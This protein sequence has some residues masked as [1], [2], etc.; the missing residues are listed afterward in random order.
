MSLPDHA[1]EVPGRKPRDD[2]ID[3]YGLTH[4]GKV[5]KT[6]NDQFLLGAVH[7]RLE[8]RLTSLSKL[9]RQSL[10]DER[11]AFV[12]M[13]ADGVGG[14]EKGGEASRVAL[15]TVSEYVATSMRAYYSADAREETFAAALQ[16]AAMRC[17]A[18]V[19]EVAKARDD[20]QGMATTLTLW[21]GVW[22][23]IYLLQVG[24]S[25][26]YM[27]HLGRL[28]QVTRDQ[29][30]AEDLVDQGVFTR[31]V[32]DRTRWA[33]VLSSALG[34]QTAAPTVTRIRSEWDA[35]HLLCSDGLTKHVTD[36]RI[37]ERLAA[38]VSAK[39]TC[40]ALLQDA[41]DDGGLRQRHDHRR[42]GH[43]EAGPRRAPLRTGLA[44][45]RRGGRVTVRTARRPYSRRNRYPT[46]D[47][48]VNSRGRAG[49]SSILCR[50]CA[51]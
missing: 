20:F 42:P 46:P 45:A 33:H 19:L 11:L 48:V 10:G 5:R 35:I 49:S 23:W 21:L 51:M 8:V 50:N 40:E 43:H 41:L 15:E 28:T 18:Q 4:M 13:V 37:A 1:A 6:N 9:E 34:G 3:V 29:T 44:A 12:S 22:P 30:M 47:S 16:E 25:R 36:E 24:D 39:Q 2:E 32:A 38:M 14:A 27:Y 26:Y 7:K 17:H 31:T